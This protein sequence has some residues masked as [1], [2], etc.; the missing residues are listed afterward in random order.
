[1]STKN[2]LPIPK[3]LWYTLCTMGGRSE[4]CITNICFFKNQFF[5]SHLLLS[6]LAVFASLQVDVILVQT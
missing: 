2:K 1:V 4:L 6:F 3:S 5:V